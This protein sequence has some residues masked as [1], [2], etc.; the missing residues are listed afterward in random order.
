MPDDKDLEIA[1]QEPVDDAESP[2]TRTI[3]RKLTR[4]VTSS[5]TTRI[6]RTTRAKRQRKRKL[7]T[8]L[9]GKGR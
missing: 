3:S 8:K 6:K 4:T 7:A 1:E 5:K 9:P 2:L